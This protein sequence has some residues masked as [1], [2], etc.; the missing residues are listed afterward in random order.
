MKNIKILILSLFIL[1]IN[2]FAE[3]NKTDSVKVLMQ[4]FIENDDEWIIIWIL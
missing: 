2:L 4:Q 1:N 3:F